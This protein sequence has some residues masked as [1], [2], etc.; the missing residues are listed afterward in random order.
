VTV[1]PQ[2]FLFLPQMRMSMDDLVVRAQVAEAAGFTGMAL[3]DH[4]S[5][6]LAAGQPMFE[7]LTTA[8]W[9]ASRTE[10]LVLGHL[11]LC[12]ALRH[13]AV[14]ARQA[15][16]LDH[17]SGGRFELGIGWGSVPEELETFGVSSRL[18]R[19]RVDRLR[20][21]LEIITRMW[22]GEPV[23]FDGHFFHVTG[24][25]QLPTPLTTIPIVIGGTGKRTLEL[26]STYADWWNVPSND[27]DRLDDVRPASGRARTSIQQMVAYI[28][29][30]DSREEVTALATRRF[31]WAGAGLRIGD[32]TELVEH[33]AALHGRG[34]E[35]FYVWFTDFAGPNTLASFG[36]GVIASFARAE[37]GSGLHR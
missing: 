21:S 32:S 37:S 15:V 7:A 13:P 27:L 12:D 33:F 26:V 10:R 9:L 30:P 24:G 22:T 23:E 2:F 8:T 35:R 11:V 28:P 3:M 5:P 34:V 31:G 20:E 4:L 36:E 1:G 19:A 18:A 25:Q 16:T 17:A 14:L 6:P 29:S